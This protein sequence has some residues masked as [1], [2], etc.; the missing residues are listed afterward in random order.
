VT[1]MRE[2]S[3]GGLENG[4]DIIKAGLRFLAESPELKTRAVDGFLDRIA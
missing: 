4:M 1:Q 2:N 3:S